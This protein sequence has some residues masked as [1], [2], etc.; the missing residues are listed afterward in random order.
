MFTSIRLLRSL[1]RYVA[2][3]MIVGYVAVMS[4]LPLP[5]AR[6]PAKTDELF[7][8]S[9]CGCGCDSAERCWTNCCCHTLAER[10]EWAAKHGVRPPEFALADARDAGLDISRWDGGSKVVRVAVAARSCCE[11]KA[12]AA[13]PSCCTK[14]TVANRTCCA[15]ESKPPQ[16]IGWRALACHGQSLHWLAAVPTLI[17][18]PLD[19]SHELPLVAWLAPP[20]SEIAAVDGDAPTPPPPERA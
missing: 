20:T 7:P 10:L 6:R 9:T 3:A 11:T 12:K 8:C 17:P 16:M 5:S 18:R 14:K 1:R 13:S 4:G 15:R 2:A 19:F